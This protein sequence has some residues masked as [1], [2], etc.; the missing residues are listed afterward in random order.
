METVHATGRKLLKA[1][2]PPPAKVGTTPLMNI[3]IAVHPTSTMTL[4]KEIELVKAA[5]LYADHVTL[6]SPAYE[7]LACMAAVGQSG[8]DTQM[9]FLADILPIISPEKVLEAQ[10]I[11]Q[12]M[13]KGHKRTAPEL[14]ALNQFRKMLPT[15]WKPL[16][17]YVDGL[18]R[19]AGAEELQEPIRLGLL[20][21]DFLD[22]NDT[23]TDE[24]VQAFTRRLQEY[25]NSARAYPMFDDQAGAIV[26]LALNAGV[27]T[28]S[29]PSLKRASEAGLGTGLID[30]LP[31]F[32]GAP[33]EA[34]L[35]TREDVQDHV[36]RFRRTVGKMRERIVSSAL[37]PQF[38]EEV[39]ELF[40]SEVRAAIE[41]IQS[42][43]D[44]SGL[45]TRLIAGANQQIAVA[46]VGLGIF[47]IQQLPLLV[48]VGV[49]G[50]AATVAA[51][52]GSQS[53]SQGK[54]E[55]EGNDLFFLYRTEVELGEKS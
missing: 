47:Q 13:G 42:A 55:A 51:V 34:V 45:R 23:T 30:R 14:I 50:A 25:L 48:K 40:V 39:N 10:L 4:A 27:F 3:T 26:R 9:Q 24:V 32:P 11:K 31:A 54:K 7:L 46:A 38:D 21:L 15:N 29:R 5:L 17:S 22:L 16:A 18:Y 8:P 28:A 49:T 44:A 36:G 6:C 2:R 35:E 52:A 41:D 19:E 12:I 33:M 43:M 20:D 53:V 1:K 37:D